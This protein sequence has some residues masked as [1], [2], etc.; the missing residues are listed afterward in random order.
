[1][2]YDSMRPNQNKVFLT[3]AVLL[4]LCIP[5]RSRGQKSGFDVRPLLPLKYSGTMKNPFA[6]KTSPTV[7]T[8]ELNDDGTFQL[9]GHAD[10]I[11]LIGKWDVTG[12]EVTKNHRKLLQFVGEIDLGYPGTGLPHGTT[13]SFSLTAQVTPEGIT[14]TYE[15]GEYAGYTV[16]QYG[17]IELNSSSSKKAFH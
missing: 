1:M 11:N 10:D 16:K 15:I 2:Q 17:T 13:A 9:S 7:M 12:N 4:F 8:L 3:V 6:H 5:L 14:G